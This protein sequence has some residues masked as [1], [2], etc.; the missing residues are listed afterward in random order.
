MA[1]IGDTM[2]GWRVKGVGQGGLGGLAQD[3]EFLAK[4]KGL[5]GD[6]LSSVLSFE[7]GD[8]PTPA[9]AKLDYAPPA[10]FA[11]LTS[12]GWTD[13]SGKNI[14]GDAGDY[15]RKTSFSQQPGFLGQFQKYLDMTAAG[16]P[17]QEAQ[18]R[19]LN[20]GPYQPEVIGAKGTAN[21][22]PATGK[23]WDSS[24]WDPASSTMKPTMAGVTPTA[25]QTDLVQ[26]AKDHG[27]A[28]AS[29][30]TNPDT[31]AA[32][33]KAKE[34]YEALTN[35]GQA[36]AEK[37][38]NL[39]QDIET[40]GSAA[41]RAKYQEQLGLAT[42]ENRA[43]M[44]RYSDPINLTDEQRAE[45]TKARGDVNEATLGVR[46]VADLNK[47]TEYQ[48]A[49]G[50]RFLNKEDKQLYSKM[51]RPGGFNVTT[52]DTKTIDP[53]TGRET[54]RT[55]ITN[56]DFQKPREKSDLNKG[57]TRFG[58]FLAGAAPGIISTPFT[59]GLGLAMA[60]FGGYTGAGGWMPTTWNNW[61]TSPGGLPSKENM[62][63]SMGLGAVGTGLGAW[64]HAAKAAK[65]A[66]AAGAARTASTGTSSAWEMGNLGRGANVLGKPMPWAW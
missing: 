38:F 41:D 50:S 48:G 47:Q 1:N 65:A 25:S 5:V 35:S 19:I 24:A 42:P 59:G 15:F 31:L 46:D 11:G 28:P 60:G 9:P 33:G 32:L 39:N 26:W 62:L 53:D 21:V 20:A 54:V 14:S 2:G 61:N 57:L 55:G 49:A 63:I 18:D 22:N 40:G 7:R 45:R 6:D 3:P 10:G 44:L 52:G 12:A 64:A 13:A 16:T 29:G 58:G 37:R 27:Y 43:M 8:T 36:L 51:G 30:F 17:K 66:Q 34:Q 23:P 4:L 56:L